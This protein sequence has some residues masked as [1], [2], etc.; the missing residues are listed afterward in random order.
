MGTLA[1]PFYEDAIAKR[2]TGK[3]QRE[4]M[5]EHIVN[6]RGPTAAAILARLAGKAPFKKVVRAYF[7]R[8]PDLFD[9]AMHDSRLAEHR[10]ALAKLAPK[11]KR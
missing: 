2:R 8:H 10:E 3:H 1:L 4:R 11:A 6:V 7:E 9:L 5:V